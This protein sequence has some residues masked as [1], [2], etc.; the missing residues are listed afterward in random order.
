MSR[1]TRRKFVSLSARGAAALAAGATAMAA[2]KPGR[3]ASAGEKVILALIGAGGRGHDLA[4]GF[5]KLENV[6][7]RYICE[8]NENR[9]GKTAEELEKLQGRRPKRALD[10]RDVFADKDV[11]AVI[12]ATPEH[13]HALATIWAC[14]AGKDVYVE[15]TPSLTVWEGRQMIEAARKYNRIVQVGTQNRSAPYG[16]S[17]R[18]YLKSGRLGKVVHVKV[19]NMLAGGPFRPQ[20]D[21]NPPPGLNWDLWLG[22]APARPFNPG[23]LNWYVWWDYCGGTLS[24]DAIHQL[25]LARMALGDPPHPRAAYCAGGRLA[26]DDRH[27]MPDTEIITYDYGTFTMTCENGTFSPYLKKIPPEIRFSDKFPNWPTTGTRIEI[28]G[29]QRLMYL[30]RHGGGWQVLDE[31]GRIVDQDPGYFP[32]KWHQPNFIECIRTR[33]RPNADIE[34]A[35]VSACLVHLGNLACRTGNQRLVFDAKTETFVGNE[36]ANRFLKPAYRKGYQVPEE[37]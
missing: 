6:E 26:F 21:A 13:W 29:T 30:G 36:A 17:A 31:T 10:M 35:H 9:G 5:A 25:D 32:D 2:A 22:P 27:E 34:Q 18:E 14:Q 19:Y 4:L 37:V 8:V 3:A 7:F 24:G 1:I 23:R 15:K 12:I 33:R 20:P 16:A 28:Y 11:H